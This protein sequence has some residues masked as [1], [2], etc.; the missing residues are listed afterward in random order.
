MPLC[1]CSDLTSLLRMNAARERECS[2]DSHP[3]AQPQG[4]ITSHPCLELLPSAGLLVPIGQHAAASGTHTTPFSLWCAT[5]AP[6][7]AHQGAYLSSLSSASGAPPDP[8]HRLCTV[9]LDG[10]GSKSNPWRHSPF[11]PSEHLQSSHRLYKQVCSD[12]AL[13]PFRGVA[14]SDSSGSKWAPPLP[15]EHHH[16]S[17]M[18]PYPVCP[19]ALIHHC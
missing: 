9:T 17:T 14:A 13:A 16:R 6:V 11:C 18:G 15:T 1:V 5:T 3:A 19:C 12:A 8:S 4:S 7:H 10:T 2:G